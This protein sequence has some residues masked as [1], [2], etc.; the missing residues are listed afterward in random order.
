M[1]DE[2][3]DEKE[4]HNNQQESAMVSEDSQKI[5]EVKKLLK[6]ATVFYHTSK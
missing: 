1:V 4:K 5:S 3:R 6:C 2:K